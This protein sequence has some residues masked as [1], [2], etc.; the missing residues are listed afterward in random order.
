[1]GEITPSAFPT[2]I[3]HTF[4]CISIAYNI[5]LYPHNPPLIHT[6]VTSCIV[7]YATLSI[8]LITIMLSTIVSYNTSHAVYM[9]WN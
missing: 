1:L 6:L 5:C 7:F 2:A 3:P 4:P 8:H 9:L